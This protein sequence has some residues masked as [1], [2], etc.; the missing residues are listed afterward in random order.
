M[1]GK[2]AGDDDTGKSGA[3]PEVGP[4]LRF[5]GEGQKLKRIRDMAGPDFGTVE[6][7][8]RFI[9]FWRSVTSSDETRP[10]GPMFHVKQ[11]R[12]SP[13]LLARGP[14]RGRPED[15]PGTVGP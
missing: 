15:R 10:A 12:D 14:A 5:G 13:Q 2:R 11:N 8:I 1:I 7:P 4:D 6:G 3:G 9:C